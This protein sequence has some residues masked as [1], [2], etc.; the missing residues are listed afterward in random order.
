MIID[1]LKNLSFT[2]LIFL[3]LG[4]VLLLASSKDSIINFIKSLSKNKPK[5]IIDITPSDKTN[6]TE[7]VSQWETLANS[8]KSANLNDAY[9]K[10]QEVFPMLISVYTTRTVKLNNEK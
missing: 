2:Q 3:S 4:V 5:P 1:F 10:L 6:L 8:C 7:I 9:N